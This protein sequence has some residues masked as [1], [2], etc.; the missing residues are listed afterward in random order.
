[1]FH[2]TTLYQNTRN[3]LGIGYTAP[4]PLLSAIEMRSNLHAEPAALQKLVVFSG[5]RVMQGSTGVKPQKAC[6]TINERNQSW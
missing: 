3:P 2:A 6:A 1:M 4:D 5:Q